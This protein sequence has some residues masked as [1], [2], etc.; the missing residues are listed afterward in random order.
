MELVLSIEPVDI[1]KRPVPEFDADVR[2]GRHRIR[3]D[4]DDERGVSSLR[5]TK[6]GRR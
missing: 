3:S 1:G 4:G 2:L 5:K 6:D